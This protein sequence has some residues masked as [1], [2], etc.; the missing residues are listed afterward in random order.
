MCYGKLDRIIDQP[1][2]K[3]VPKKICSLLLLTCRPYTLSGPAENVAYKSQFCQLLTYARHMC[4]FK[5]YFH[6]NLSKAGGIFDEAGL[7]VE[8]IHFV[9][10]IARDA[11]KF[12]LHN[13]KQRTQKRDIAEAYPSEDLIFCRPIYIFPNI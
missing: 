3:G 4:Y 10:I 12:S 11:L 9:C 1:K 8:V 7:V 13:C 5:T 6:M 2:K